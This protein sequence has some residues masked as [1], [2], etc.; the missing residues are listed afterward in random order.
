MAGIILKRNKEGRAMGKEKE[1]GG[2]VI[3]LLVYVV[4]YLF[5]AC[6]DIVP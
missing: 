5:E 2:E 3:M 4:K 6:S 1:R